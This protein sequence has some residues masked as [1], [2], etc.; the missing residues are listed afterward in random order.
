M[1]NKTISESIK[2][3]QTEYLN[4]AQDWYLGFSGGKD[5]TALLIVV[6]N[7]VKNISNPKCTIHVI[8]CDTGVEFPQITNLVYELFRNLREEITRLRNDIVFEIVKPSV[9]DRYFSM[10]IGNGYVPPT[11][12][13]RWC[14]RRLRINPIQKYIYSNSQSLV[15]LGIRE[16]ESS[17]R[18]GV[19]KAHRLSEYYT[20][21]TGATGTTIFCPII[22]F[23]VSDVWE[24]IDINYPTTLDRSLIRNLYSYIGSVFD[25]GKYISDTNCGRYGCWVCTVIRKDKAMEGLIAYGYS[26]LIPLKEFVEWLKSIRNDEKRRYPNRLTGVEGKGPFSLD[27]RKEILNQLLKV[28]KKTNYTLITDEEIEYIHNV[29]CET[30]FC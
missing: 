22:H 3:V 14:T 21:Q 20:K 15:I 7:A 1:L 23:S 27:T 19:I 18:D 24:T 26:E 10:I 13:F 2:L 25:N 6:L 9:N 17:T 5:S 4:A 12:L 8:Y 29:W 11:F 16:G 28:Q 30:D